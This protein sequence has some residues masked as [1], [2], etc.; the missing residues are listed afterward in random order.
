MRQNQASFTSLV[1][2]SERLPLIYNFLKQVEAT[3]VQTISMGQG[4]KVSRIIAWTFRSKKEQKEWTQ[5]W[6]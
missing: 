5:R 2:K 4:N 1:S 3:E 6:K